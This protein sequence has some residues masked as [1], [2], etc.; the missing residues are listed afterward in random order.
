MGRLGRVHS[1]FYPRPARKENISEN[2]IFD[3]EQHWTE[4]GDVGQIVR[5]F[6]K[7]WEHSADIW[8]IGTEV[9][10]ASCFSG[11][12]TAM[13]VINSPERKL[14]KCTYAPWIDIGQTLERH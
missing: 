12:F 13:A 7:N 10:F 11:G 14:A 6:C 1:I 8:D 2:P 5:T 4:I 3:L 9:H